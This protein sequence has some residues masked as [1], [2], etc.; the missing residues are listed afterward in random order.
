MTTHTSDYSRV[1][2]RDLF[3]EAKL[4]KCLGHVMLAHVNDQ[5]PQLKVRHDTDETQGW[6]IK[7][8]IC[9]HLFC[10]NMVFS[11]KARR[12]YLATAVNDRTC[13]PLLYGW[14][15]R[16]ED[17]TEPVFDSPSPAGELVRLSENF[18]ELCGGA[19][20]AMQF[21][22]TPQCTTETG[23]WSS[24]RSNVSDVS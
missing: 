20:R 1:M 19:R 5:L 12:L 7:M 3:N 14:S 17:M 2:P 24:N 16:F 21:S 10:S 6:A 4:L 22:R 18:L 23:R 9:G 13:W 15:A 8:S 11:V